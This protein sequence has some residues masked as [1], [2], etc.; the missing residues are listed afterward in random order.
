MKGEAVK[1][2]AGDSKEIETKVAKSQGDN[3]QSVTVK[4]QAPPSPLHEAAAVGNVEVVRF[5][6]GHCRMDANAVDLVTGKTALQLAQDKGHAAV[7][8][9][10]MVRLRVRL[11]SIQG[12]LQT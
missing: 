5:L 2:G 8:E 4:Q 12:V 6:V 11:C 10:L 7:V 1:S 9:L 3:K